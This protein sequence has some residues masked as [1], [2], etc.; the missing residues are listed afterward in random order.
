MLCVRGVCPRTKYGSGL[1]FLIVI[2]M[3]VVGCVLLI[4]K[5]VRCWKLLLDECGRGGNPGGLPASSC[6]KFTLIEFYG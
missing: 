3:I 6:L 5:I 2:V 1:F 4:F